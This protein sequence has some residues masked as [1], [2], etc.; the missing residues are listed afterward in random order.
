M[1]STST[2][3]CSNQIRNM[4]P[5]EFVTRLSAALTAEQISFATYSLLAIAYGSGKPVSIMSLSRS[6]GMTYQAV[7]HQIERTPWWDIVS[8]QRGRTV[9]VSTDGVLKLSRISTLLAG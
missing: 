6:S 5:C 7:R 1:K 3:S 4:T 2:P 8:H 9:S